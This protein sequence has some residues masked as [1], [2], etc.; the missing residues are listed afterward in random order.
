MRGD[1]A[2]VICELVAVGVFAPLTRIDRHPAMRRLSGK[3]G[4]VDS[5]EEIMKLFQRFDGKGKG[6]IDFADV[7]SIAK[8]LGENMS[9]ADLNNMVVQ[10][11]TDGRV[12]ADQFYKLL[13]TQPGEFNIIEMYADSSDEEQDQMR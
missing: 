11:G 8:E 7:K 6:Y 9:D 4:Q 10:F 5:Q 1:V 3:M 2:L 13:R 12:N